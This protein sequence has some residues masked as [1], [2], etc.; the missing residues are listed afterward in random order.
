MKRFVNMLDP[1]FHTPRTCHSYYRQMRLVHEHC[2]TDPESIT[3]ECEAVPKEP[4]QLRDYSGPPSSTPMASIF[5][6]WKN[7]TAPSKSA[8]KTNSTAANQKN[9]GVLSDHFVA[10]NL[11]QPERTRVE[12]DPI[13]QFPTFGNLRVQTGYERYRK[14]HGRQF[15]DIAQRPASIRVKAQHEIDNY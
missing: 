1:R 10:S 15:H 6:P 12:N 8:R 3:E 4:T 11:R 14:N 13:E 7:P 9:A 2:E 5:S